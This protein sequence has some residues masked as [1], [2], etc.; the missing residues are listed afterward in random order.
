MFF[1]GQ[2]LTHFPQQ[3]QALGSI[4]NLSVWGHYHVKTKIADNV[5]YLGSLFRDSFGEESPKGY[6]IIEDN[7]FEFIENNKAYKRSHK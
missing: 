7:K 5:Y 2:S 1:I 4:C 6:G 3:I